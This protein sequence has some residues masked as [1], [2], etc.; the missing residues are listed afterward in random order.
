MDPRTRS[1]LPFDSGSCLWETGRACQSTRTQNKLGK[2]QASCQV[3][4]ETLVT[5]K[6]LPG[7]PATHDGNNWCK[8]IA[9][10]EQPSCA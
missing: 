7:Q 4:S 5:T 3:Q 6:T 8:A 10:K 1:T 9:V 2:G